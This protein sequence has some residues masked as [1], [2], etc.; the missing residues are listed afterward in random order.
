MTKRISTKQIALALPN[1]LG[2]NEQTKPPLLGGASKSI[3]VV[4]DRTISMMEP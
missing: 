2:T 1:E 3:D 4:V